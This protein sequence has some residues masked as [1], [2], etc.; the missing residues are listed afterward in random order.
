MHRER[1]CRRVGVWKLPL[2]GSVRRW[3]PAS[4]ESV[5][6]I[7]TVVEYRKSETG[8]YHATGAGWLPQG[9]HPEVLDDRVESVSLEGYLGLR[10]FS[11]ELFFLPKGE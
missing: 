5:S 4:K 10:G 11:P 7:D 9:L 3:T 1:P 8:G 2:R 6:E